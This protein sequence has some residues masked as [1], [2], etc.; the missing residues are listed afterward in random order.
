MSTNVKEAPNNSLCKVQC[1]FGLQL[2]SSLSLTCSWGQ[3]TDA[4][5]GYTASSR[6]LN[7]FLHGLTITL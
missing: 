1:R 5:E 2:W 3:V 6:T 7:I 4:E